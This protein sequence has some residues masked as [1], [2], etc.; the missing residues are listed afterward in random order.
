MGVEGSGE[1]G[2]DVERQGDTVGYA[3]VRHEQRLSTAMAETERR[4]EQEILA[5]HYEKT[6]QKRCK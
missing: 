1:A 3:E 4:H 6:N 2:E 5:R